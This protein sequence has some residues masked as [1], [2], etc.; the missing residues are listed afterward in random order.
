M[1]KYLFLTVAGVLAF[2]PVAKAAFSVAELQVAAK[3]G[4]EAFQKA[5]P[6]HSTHFIGYKAW[7]SGEESKL[8]IYVNHEGTTSEFSYLC[9]KHEHEHDSEPEIECHAQ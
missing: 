6:E 4:I 5:Q 9:H 8:K 7:F 1:T 2:S 3:L